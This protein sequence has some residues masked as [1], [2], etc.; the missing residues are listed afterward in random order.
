MKNHERL[1]KAIVKAFKYVI[2]V[3]AYRVMLTI[4]I[5]A[6]NESGITKN[7]FFNSLG[8]KLD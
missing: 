7:D 3:K 8:L 5:C 1:I 2:G 6:K 4:K